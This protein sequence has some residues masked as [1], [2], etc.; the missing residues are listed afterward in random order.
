MELRTFGKYALVLAAMAVAPLRQANAATL[1]YEDFETG[2]ISG[3]KW[4]SN[5]SGS[6]ITDPVAAGHG[7]VLHFS[8]PGSGGDLFTYLMAYSAPVTI[9][10]DFLQLG[11]NNTGGF[12]GTDHQTFPYG[13]EQWILNTGGGYAYPNMNF[14]LPGSWAHVSLTFTPVDTN[15]IG[16]FAAK[17]EQVDEGFMGNAYFDNIQISDASPETA[18]EPESIALALTG[19]AMIFLLRRR[20]AV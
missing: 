9:Q 4:A 2:V 6:L 19:A 20:K 3:A 18:P 17:F 15:N 7:W 1:F 8:D 5:I 14:L 13:D 10:F 11:S 12:V 16:T